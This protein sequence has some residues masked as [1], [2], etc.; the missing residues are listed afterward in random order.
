MV[1]SLSTPLNDPPSY[2][3]LFLLDSNVAL[4]ICM[5]HP[6]NK[7]CSVEIMQELQAMLNSVNPYAQLFT[8]M[9]DISAISVNN[10]SLKFTTDNTFDRRRYNRL[11]T[12][13][14][15][16]VFVSNDGA[17]S[18]KYDFIIYAKGTN[19]LH[20][21]SY[22]NPH[23]NPMCYPLLFPCG[24]AGWKPGL[25]HVNIYS[26][27]VRNVMTQL[28]YY[29]YRIAMRDEF[30]IIHASG[31]L[32]QQFVVDSYIKVEGSRI[33]YIK[34]HQKE[35]RAKNYKGLIDFLRSDA[36]ERGFKAVIPVILPSSHIGSP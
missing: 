23:C 3:G 28:Q 25:P 15:S 9:K 8:S 5:T 18:G 31:K 11:S 32:F 17:P 1:G 20:R 29:C 16:A 35:L 7:N 4:D 30:S 10:L 12:E 2:A 33:A 6:E 19:I 34:S 26:T 13:E 27:T 21:I 36:R 22:L 14:I 24:D